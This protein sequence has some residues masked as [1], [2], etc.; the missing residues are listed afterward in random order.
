MFKPKTNK[1]I[2]K[3]TTMT[4]DAKHS[5][6]MN[7]Y[8]ENEEKIPNLRSEVNELKVLKKQA[9]SIESRNTLRDEINAKKKLI[10][11]YQN[12]KTNYLLSNCNHIFDYFEKKQDISTGHNSK[13]SEIISTF[14]DKCTSVKDNALNSNLNDS[15]NQ[16]FRN[17]DPMTLDITSFM[18]N[19]N[20]CSYCNNEM[21]VI[22]SEGIIVCSKC[23]VYFNYIIEC[24]KPS[25]KEPP[26]EVSF[27][28]Y[29][30]INHFRE[31]LAQFQAKESTHISDDIIN[32]IKLQI[33]K[34]RVTLKEITNKKTKEILK[35]LGL[36]NC[37]EHISFIREKLGIKPPVMSHELEDTLCNLF[38]Q[39]QSPYSRCC[40]DDRVNFLNY[41][42]TIYKLCEMLG[43][44]EFLSHF[45]MLK[46]REK[47]IEQDEIWKNI[48]NELEW[49]YI[50]TV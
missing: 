4:L 7:Q 28:V 37:Y 12:E 39:M 38:M 43:H 15:I 36:S 22:E 30:R 23:G 33:I 21:I 18:I 42:Y 17:I 6:L 11:I 45:P 49:N 2:K 13:K 24:E 40:P 48:C 31:I 46:D 16:Y 34:E 20:T 50:P 41:Y 10:L 1:N 3:I 35:K 47:R 26:K 9:T 29:K 8:H 27:Y 5:Q 32:R 25:Y 19:S 44:V 14:F